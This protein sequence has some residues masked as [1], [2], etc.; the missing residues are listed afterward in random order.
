M[1]LATFGLFFGPR[2]ALAAMWVLTDRVDEAFD[3]AVWPALGLA[4]VPSATILYVL[5]WTQ[6]VGGGGV[7]GAEWVIVGLGAALDV[8]IWVTRL[9]PERAP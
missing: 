2:I 8:A 9:L 7:T 3:R 5:L 6:D 4:F 1:T